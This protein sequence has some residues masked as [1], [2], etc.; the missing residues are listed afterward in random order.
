[1]SVYSEGGAV[2]MSCVEEAVSHNVV[3]RG[4]FLLYS[5]GFAV[6]NGLKIEFHPHLHSSPPRH[7]CSLSSVFLFLYIQ[8]SPK[9]VKYIFCLFLG[10]LV[11]KL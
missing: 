11:P 10:G 5:G 7:Q 1:M 9:P 4:V 3:L 2:M 8:K 6:N